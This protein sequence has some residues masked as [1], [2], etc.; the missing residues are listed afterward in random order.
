MQ[1]LKNA[2]TLRVETWP[3]FWEVIGEILFKIL[4]LYIVYLI[5]DF[6]GKWIEVG[7]VTSNTLLSIVVLPAIYVL[8][9]AYAIFTPFTVT[10]SLSDN[11]ITV[12]QGIYTKRLDCLKLDT[13]EN[14]ELITTALGRYKSYGTLDLY[15]YVSTIQIPNVKDYLNI[16]DDIESRIEACKRSEPK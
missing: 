15:S 12:E 4:G 9:D 6:I 11:D 7:D 1:D 14:V 8:K 13:V 3:I 2:T 10:I 5:F 16:K